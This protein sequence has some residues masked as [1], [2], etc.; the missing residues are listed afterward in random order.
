MPYDAVVA[1]VAVATRAFMMMVLRERS[2]ELLQK[3]HIMQ[4]SQWFFVQIGR[5]C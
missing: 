1:V 5:G 3:L 2:A 4:K